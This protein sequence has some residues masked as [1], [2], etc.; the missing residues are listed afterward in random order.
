M[1]WTRSSRSIPVLV[2]VLAASALWPVGS[3]GGVM[4][5]DLRGEWLVCGP[6]AQGSCDAAQQTWTISSMSLSSGQFSGYGGGNSY[7]WSLSGAAAGDSVQL[8]TPYNEVDYTADFSGAIGTDADVM[9]GTWTDSWSQSG[10]WYAERL[11]GPPVNSTRPRITGTAY[12]GH[13]LDCD[14]GTWKRSPKRFER[15]WRRDG[16]EIPGATGRTYNVGSEDTGR[17]LSCAV[18]AL[19]DFG[20]ASATSDPVRGIARY[21]IELKAWIPTPRV[22][23]PV[24]PLEGIPYAAVPKW[25]RDQRPCTTP[26]TPLPSQAAFLAFRERSFV[27]SWYRGD[28]HREYDGIFRTRPVAKFEWDGERVSAFEVS[29]ES[30]NYNATFQ[31]TRYSVLWPKGAEITCTQ[32][33]LQNHSTFGGPTTHDGFELGLESHNP[34]APRLPGDYDVSPA[35]DSI[36]KGHLKGAGDLQIEYQT[37]LFPS[38]GVRVLRDGV[39]QATHTVNDL[40][41]LKDSDTLGPEA[42]VLLATGLSLPV[43]LGKY[44]VPPDLVGYTESRRGL[45]CGDAGIWALTQVLGAGA[46]TSPGRPRAAAAAPKISIAAVGPGGPEPYLPLATAEQRGIVTVARLADRISLLTRADTP[47]LVRV[48]G[49]NVVVETSLHKGAAKTG[50]AVYGPA[51][52]EVVLAPTGGEPATVNGRKLKARG[53][54]RKPPRTIA[55]V[56]PRRGGRALVRLRANDVSGVASTLAYVGERSVKLAKGRLT[57]RAS[58]LNK[59]RFFSVDVFGNREPGR[60]LTARQ[61]RLR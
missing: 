47:V 40:S 2:A 30:E 56:T 24:L 55:T 45:L 26:D 46:G 37:D 33:A 43:N 59:L 28:N 52:G 16:V 57:L 13:D 14:D 12:L 1:H 20:E 6:G 36:I 50:G 19:N 49:R 32:T 9:S 15:S 54:D 60:R 38:H 44:T 39:V 51:S 61:T 35:I 11:S 18:T 48:T 5:H 29:P 58:D 21:A 17:E 53:T 31:E 22:V 34:L 23:D 8:T 42:I 27:T 10:S 25:I 41:C 3:A 4:P 7:T